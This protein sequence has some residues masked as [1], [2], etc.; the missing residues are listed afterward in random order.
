MLRFVRWWKWWKEARSLW[1]LIFVAL[2]A[3]W[4]VRATQGAGFNEVRRWVAQS[5]QQ[6]GRVQKTLLDA[7]TQELNQRVEE[8]EVQ[9]AKLKALLNIPNAASQKRLN[10]AITARSADNWWQQLTLG[11]GSQDG[12]RVDNVVTAPGGLVGRVMAVTPNTSRVLLLT[13]P[14][15]QIG[16]NVSR[17]R[18]VGIFRGQRGRFGVLEFFQKDPDV[19]VNDTVVTSSLSSRFPQ[20]IPIGRV[21]VL[22]LDQLPA[23]QVIVELTT[24]IENLEWA[25]VLING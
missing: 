10:A 17:S 11:K 14:S 3:A 20:G 18:Q 22:K 4:V 12:I 13:D 6:D 9:N 15:S 23:P 25:T 2:S 24:P 16:A 19:K 7:Q 5:L 8:L 21:T 1:L